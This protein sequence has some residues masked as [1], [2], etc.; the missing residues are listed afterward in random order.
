MVNPLL[1]LKKI[2]IER[3]ATLLNTVKS[4]HSEKKQGTII[5]FADFEREQEIF[6]QESSF[7]Y[8]T[9]VTEPGSVLV[10]NWDGKSTLYVPNTGGTR[11]QWI[12]GA[13]DTS[14]ESIEDAG[15][16]AIEY[17]GDKI[18]GYE[19]APF[20]SESDYKNIIELLEN[21]TK[22]GSTIFSLNPSTQNGYVVQRHILE[23][24]NSFV[25]A[26]KEAIYDISS[27][28]AD[29]RSRKSNEEIDLLYNAIDITSMGHEA[30]AKMIAPN[31][32]ESEVHAT[33]E[34][35]FTAAQAQLAFPS[36]VGSGK[37]S[38]VLHYTAN[39]QPLEKDSLVVVDCGARFYHYCADLTRT[40]PVS[41]K[42]TLR[43]KELYQ[44]VLDC[45]AYIAE[46]AKPGMWLNNKD[47]PEESL[48]HL[49]REFFKKKDLDQY[50]VH[51]I[52]HYL[53]LDTHD[54]GDY[55]KP[56]EEGNVITIEPGL[57]LPQENIGIRIEDNYWIVKSGAVCLSEALPKSVDQIEN[58]AKET[59]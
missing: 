8:M 29:M 13:L 44:L 36:I 14:A 41:G 48:N 28:L 3:R 46:I 21:N 23:R 2:Y 50:F 18:K 12:E 37:N 30:A 54:V 39:N 31:R 47:K 40:Y 17:L 53:G 27:I 57:Y 5:L 51:G 49:A 42:F 20:F 35:V 11:Q 38:T 26:L 34:Y 1:D 9:G 52:G 22:G 25:P 10:M 59:F 15:V 43:Q 45:Q 55:S 19:L 16:D 32:S 56:L 4:L 33:V 24:L 6:T 7:Y 58:L